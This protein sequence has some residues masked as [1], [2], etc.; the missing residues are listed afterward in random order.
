MPKE[1]P[2]PVVQKVYQDGKSTVLFQFDHP[3]V[4]LPEEQKVLDYTKNE[5]N[6]YE[7]V[8]VD[9]VGHTDNK[10]SDAYNEKLGKKRAENVANEIR[11]STDPAKVKVNSVR[12]AGEKEPAFPNDT[13]EGRRKNRRVEINFKG[14]FDQQEDIH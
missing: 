12:S 11:N 14:W 4:D 10:G 2:V 3:A 9:V 5:L 7:Y 13:A 8:D 6:K 1:E